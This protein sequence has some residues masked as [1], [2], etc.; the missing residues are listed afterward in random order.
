MPTEETQYYIK[1]NADSKKNKSVIWHCL[2]Q[3]Q[4]PQKTTVIRTFRKYPECN[5]TAVFLSITLSEN[6]EKK[7]EKHS[8]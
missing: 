7:L 2:L 6:K 1:E 4:A 3:S 5:N 8:S